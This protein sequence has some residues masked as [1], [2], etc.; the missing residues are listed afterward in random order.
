M[1]TV[2]WDPVQTPSNKGLKP[3]PEATLD[4]L[5]PHILALSLYPIL[6]YVFLPLL[7]SLS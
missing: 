7:S 5:G 2:K 4:P 6:M 3:S 1:M